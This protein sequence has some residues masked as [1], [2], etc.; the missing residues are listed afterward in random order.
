M[1]YI[2]RFAL[3]IMGGNVLQQM[4]NTLDSVIV[5]RYVGEHGLAAVG[6]ASPIMSLLVFF[7]FGVG[8]GMTVLLAQRYGNGDLE[9]F[10]R[11][12]ATALTGGCLFCVPLTLL[13]VL[14]AQPVLLLLRTPP[15]ILGQAVLYLRIVFCG[16]I[17][18]FLYNYHSAALMAIGDSKTPFYALA[19]SSVLNVVLDVLFVGPMG[20]GVGGAALA[21]VIAQGT[22]SV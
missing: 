16:L 6:V 8:L 11:N 15:E 2:L 10:R 5:G 3:P 18:T 21:T 4:Y 17:F 12:A 13:C 19:I 7:L 14:L 22:S 9:E 20:M 1:G